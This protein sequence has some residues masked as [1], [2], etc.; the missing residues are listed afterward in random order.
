MSTVGKWAFLAGLVLA[1]IVGLVIKGDLIPWAVAALGVIVGLLNI[2]A[3]EVKSFL[4][5]ATGLT[6][7]LISIQ[8]QYYNPQWV[9]DVVFF[10]KV[11][12]THALLVVGFLAFFRTARD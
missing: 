7:A 4:L 1:L 5:A 12:I 2:K 11:F 10:E 3:S 9:T 6:V 8:A